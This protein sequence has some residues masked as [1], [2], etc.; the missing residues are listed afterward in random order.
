MRPLLAALLPLALAASPALAEVRVETVKIERKSE[1]ADIEMAYPRTG[2]STLDAT[3]ADWVNGMVADFEKGA[4]EDFASFKADNNGELPPWTY[5]LYL[6]FEVARNDDAML[7]F[8]FD[9]SIYQG[10]AHPNHDI[11]TFNV[12]MPDAWRVYLPE[13]FNGKPALDRISALA[14]EQLGKTLLGPDSMSDPD[15]VK[16]G[17]GPQ[18]SN[19][20][21]FLLL[22]DSL[23]I[24]FPP[25]QVAAYAAGDQ[26]VE[27]PLEKLAGLM[28]TDWRVPVASFDCAKA[29]SAPE[30]AICSDVALAR[31][32]RQLSDSYA[33]A[34][35][36]ASDD[37]EKNAIRSAQRAWI[38]ER[39]ACGGDVA[40]LTS[41]Y[42]KR[43]AA[44]QAASG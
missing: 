18:W 30:K 6:G 42:G 31:L 15:W 33:Q 29:G 41:A 16:S 21:D 28:R 8:D 44:L 9:E 1:T 11:I 39:N 20:Q 3:F 43:L 2:I 14:I 40:C 32:D 17:A 26:K 19:F 23:V 4:E 36:W 7:V 37:A 13:I 5:S 25:Y 22:E 12:M 24:R 27:I 34:L 35:S 38:G 10:G